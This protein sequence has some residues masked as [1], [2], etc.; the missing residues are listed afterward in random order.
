[1]SAPTPGPW[2]VT[3]VDWPEGYRIQ[4][5]VSG[6][7]GDIAQVTNVPDA[8]LIAAAPALLE[9]VEAYYEDCPCSLHACRQCT[10][11]RAA[12]QAARKE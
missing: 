1:M 5:V 3:D 10:Q 4:A 7:G 8:S 12:I 2:N 6:P 11:A 9:A